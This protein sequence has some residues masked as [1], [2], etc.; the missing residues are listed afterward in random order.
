MRTFGVSVLALAV[1][2]GALALPAAGS[3]RAD[4]TLVIRLVSV[5]TSTR[6]D[7]RPPRGPTAGDKVFSTSRLRNAVAQFGK[8][9]NAVVGSDRGTLTLTSAN[10]VR[11][12]VTARLPGGTLRVRGPLR[13]LANGGQRYPVVGGT[14]RFAG[15]RGTVTVRPL[16]GAGQRASNVYRLTLP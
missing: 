9:R 1:V 5:T 6:V 14:G 16:S 12:D 7:D 10:S 2:V 4:A 11:I 3:A 15:A 13:T 8:P